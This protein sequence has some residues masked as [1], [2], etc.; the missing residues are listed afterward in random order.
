MILPGPFLTQACPW[1]IW[2]AQEYH[3][4]DLIK[5]S[6]EICLDEVLPQSDSSKGCIDVWHL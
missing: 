1:L 4:M 3:G 6:G 2:Y 5:C